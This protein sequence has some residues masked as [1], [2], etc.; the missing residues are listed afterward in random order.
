MPFVTRKLLILL[1]NKMQVLSV[2]V[3][4]L[5]RQRVHIVRMHDR[6]RVINVYL[7][8]LKSIQTNV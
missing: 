7:L 2:R 3:Q 8:V 1:L 6:V 4:L 5:R